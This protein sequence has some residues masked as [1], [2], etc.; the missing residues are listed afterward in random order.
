MIALEPDS[1]DVVTLQLACLVTPPQWL[2]K[3]ASRS[4]RSP[5]GMCL[6]F[7]CCWKLFIF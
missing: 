4:P 2:T 7:L 1:Y 5:S 6:P 3:S